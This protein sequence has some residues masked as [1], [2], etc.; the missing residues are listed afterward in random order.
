MTGVVHKDIRLARCQCGGD[1][2]L[3]T[4]TYPF[5]VPVNDVAGVEIAEALSDVRQLA[6][7]VSV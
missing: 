3:R 2:R 5:E 4:A 1:L 6:T 7:G